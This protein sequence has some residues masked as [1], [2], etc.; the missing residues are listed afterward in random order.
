MGLSTWTAEGR[1]MFNI[2]HPIYLLTFACYYP[3]DTV[4][5]I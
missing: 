2:L 1:D 4:R 5:D 3:A